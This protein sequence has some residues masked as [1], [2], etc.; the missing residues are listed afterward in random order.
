[1][2]KV[3]PCAGRVDD[4]CVANLVRGWCDPAA[5]TAIVADLGRAAVDA[6]ALLAGDGDGGEGGGNE[7]WII[8]LV[9]IDVN[10][11]IKLL[12]SMLTAMATAVESKAA[13]SRTAICG[14]GWQ[15]G[16]SCWDE[17]V[18]ESVPVRGWEI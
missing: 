10:V 17:R 15:R 5:A 7:G 11:D 8:F 4:G 13:E 2:D 16:C 3:L 18:A 6:A 12:M 14:A 1:M 9:V